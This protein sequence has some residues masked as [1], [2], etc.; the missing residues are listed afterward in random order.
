VELQQHG[1]LLLGAIIEKVTGRSYFDYVRGN[2]YAP[3]GM[4]NTDCYEMDDVVPNLAIAY[5][6]MTGHWT[7]NLFMHVIKGGP[8][9]GGFSTVEDLLRFDVALRQPQAA[10]PPGTRGS[11]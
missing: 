6:R 8:A 7:S 3:A 4:A 11:C 1:V 10:Q 2:V 9:G 5:T